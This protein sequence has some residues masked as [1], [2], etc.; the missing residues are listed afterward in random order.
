VAT[1]NAKHGVSH[2]FSF[3]HRFLRL[4]EMFDQRIKQKGHLDVQ[5]MI[6]G[7]LDT[8]DLQAQLSTEYII[9]NVEKGL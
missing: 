2:A 7:Q 8:V 9:K 6:D 5:D 3:T 1:K 4:N